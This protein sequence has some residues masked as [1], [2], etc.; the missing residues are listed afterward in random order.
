MTRPNYYADFDFGYRD[1][2]DV[3]H[4]KACRRVRSD[5]TIELDTDEYGRVIAKV[6]A[7]HR[8]SILSFAKDFFEDSALAKTFVEESV[9]RF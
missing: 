1:F 3:E 2:E 6:Y 4:D 5:V 9:H 7:L 8:D